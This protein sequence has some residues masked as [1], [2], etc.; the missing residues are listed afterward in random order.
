ME[1]ANPEGT[2]ILFAAADRLLEC[3]ASHFTAHDLYAAA[4]TIDLTPRQEVIVNLDYAQRGLGTASCGPD[5]L[6][7]YLLP[8]GDYWF[9]YRITF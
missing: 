8:P 1:L 2:A 9:G 3:S 6:D 7:Q 5:T 4:H